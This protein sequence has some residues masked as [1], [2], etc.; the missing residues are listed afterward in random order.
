MLKAR[1]RF[2]SFCLLLSLA[3]PL[4]ERIRL[5]F[6]I[7]S[8]A[9]TILPLAREIESTDKNDT[10]AWPDAACHWRNFVFLSSSCNT[11]TMLL[12]DLVIVAHCNCI[13]RKYV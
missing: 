12:N 8:F 13:Q 3:L 6:V 11:R 2:V 1:T 9:L 7:S 5:V 10:I 4:A